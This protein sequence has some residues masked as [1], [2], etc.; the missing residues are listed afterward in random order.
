MYGQKNVGAFE[1]TLVCARDWISSEVLP[2]IRDHVGREAARPYR[3]FGA[4]QGF[5]SFD[6]KGAAKRVAQ[7]EVVFFSPAKHWLQGVRS[8]G[9][10]FFWFV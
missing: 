5:R 4:V 3:L 7:R 2:V 1:E 6:P 8:S 10:L 9:P